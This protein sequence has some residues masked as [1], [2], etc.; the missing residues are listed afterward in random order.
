MNKLIFFAFVLV[1]IGSCTEKKI[2]IPDFEV[3]KTDKVVLIEEL[4]GVKCINCP[5][6]ARIVAGLE[7]KYEGKVISIAIHGGDLSDP[8]DDSKYDL[9]CEDGE[10]LENIFLPYLGKPAAAIDRI[11]SEDEDGIPISGANGWAAQVTKALKVKSKVSLFNTVT[12]DAESRELNVSLSIVAKQDLTGDF[13]VS[14][15]L[16]EDHIVDKQKDGDEIDEEFEFEN[17]LRD[18]LTPFDGESIGTEL[19]KEVAINKT[20]SVTLPPSDGTWIPENMNIVIYVTGG[21]ES[22]FF[23]VVDAVKTKVIQ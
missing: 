13:K 2:I 7:E 21:E 18:M 22:S 3:P 10:K 9:R 16:T 11:K 20:Y 8:F 1:L 4:T 19:E 12:Y 5:N 6:G 17:V 14:V 23:P 15:A